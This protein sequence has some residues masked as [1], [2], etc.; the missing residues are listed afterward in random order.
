M[1]DNSNPNKYEFR[2]AGPIIDSNTRKLVD[3]FTSEFKNAYYVGPVYG[4]Q[5]E[6]FLNA[7]DIFYFPS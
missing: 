6:E 2:I 3:A 1:I 7:S 4:E 5:K